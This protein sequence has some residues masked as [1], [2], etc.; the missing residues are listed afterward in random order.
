MH[1]GKENTTDVL[2]KN[3][4]GNTDLVKTSMLDKLGE[5][6]TIK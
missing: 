3:S 1:D 5:F 6:E 4:S 2:L